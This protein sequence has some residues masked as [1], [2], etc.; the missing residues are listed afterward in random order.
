MPFKGVA[1]ASGGDAERL[2]FDWDTE[3]EIAR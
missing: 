2:R 3:K 1:S